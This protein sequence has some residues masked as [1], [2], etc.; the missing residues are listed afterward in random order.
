MVIIVDCLGK[1]HPTCLLL[2]GHYQTYPS[3]SRRGIC[4]RKVD[5]YHVCYCID[6]MDLVDGF[7][8]IKY[9]SFSPLV[10]LRK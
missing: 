2:Q 10:R 8:W 9:A 7:V 3:Q 5:I 4:C 6:F 1:T